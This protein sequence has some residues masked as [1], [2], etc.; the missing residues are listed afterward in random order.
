MEE[1]NKIDGIVLREGNN[2]RTAGK[3]NLV[4]WKP[5]QSGNPKGRPKGAKTGLRVRLIQ[6]LEAQGDKTV[7]DI[8]KA[9]GVEL[10][11][12]DAAAVIAY[13]LTRKAQSGDV[14]AS[15]QIADQTELPQPKEVKLDG[16]LKVTSIERRI[17]DP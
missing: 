11:D 10:K 3:G 6:A 2:G 14:Q 5:G 1:N 13:V 4:N 9:K 16:D 17:I 8:L 12:K 15:K 7:L